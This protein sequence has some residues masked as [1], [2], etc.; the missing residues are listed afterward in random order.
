MEPSTD[1]QIKTRIGYALSDRL[2][3]IACQI[4][5][6]IT[7]AMRLI[8]DLPSVAIEA[9]LD[10]S[11]EQHRNDHPRTELDRAYKNVRAALLAY[12][13][14][15]LREARERERHLLD[16]ITGRHNRP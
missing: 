13:E 11:R 2:A 14:I 6:N 9:L 15:A 1:T 16:G 12:G 4:V 3:P 7:T 5:K 10:Y 8:D